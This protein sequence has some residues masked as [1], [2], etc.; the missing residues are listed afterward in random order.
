MEGFH[1]CIIRDKKEIRPQT[2]KS[3]RMIF[4][5]IYEVLNQT[6][7]DHMESLMVLDRFNVL[8]AGDGIIPND[9][10]HPS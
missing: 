9:F 8:D 7:L 4:I 3:P 5:R 1:S 2:S 6:L 10:A